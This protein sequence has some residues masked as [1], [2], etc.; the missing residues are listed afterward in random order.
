MID[1]PDVALSVRQPWA[2]SIVAGYKKIENRSAGSIKTGGMTCRRIAVHAATGMKQDEYDWGA[3]RLDKHGVRC[4]RPDALVR[5]AIIGAVDVVDIVSES[6]SEWFGGQMGLV[7]ENAV[8]CEP[9]PA[10]GEL[11][12]FRWEREEDFAAINSWMVRWG[13]GDAGLFGD[14]APSWKEAPRKPF[15][16]TRED[17]S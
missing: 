17:T 1:L 8:A 14:L 3:W 4:P 16:G 5:G 13:G 6:E 2:W 11:G 12:Y 10:K 9:I 7:L 15:G